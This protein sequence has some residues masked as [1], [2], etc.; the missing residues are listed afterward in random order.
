[1]EKT[2]FC[3][4]CGY[5]TNQKGHLIRHFQNKKPCPSTIADVSVED[6]LEEL[7][8][9]QYNDHTY[10]CEFCGKKF[11]SR[12]NKS[13]H[14]RTCKPTVSV[15][16]YMDL[17]TK[18]EALEQQVKNEAPTNITNNT[19][20]IQQN[21][22]I[23]IQRNDFARGENIKYLQPQFLLECFRDMDMIKVLEEIHFNPDHP[24]N[25]NVR[26][27]NVKQNLMEYIDNGQWIAK[28][29]EEVLDHLIMNGY[30]VLHTYY[31]DNKDD[32]EDNLENNEV[33]ESLRWLKMIYHEDKDVIKQLKD[34]A[35]LLVMNNK[36][37]LLQ[38]V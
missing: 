20:N 15:K 22:H 2:Y 37:L 4:R 14:K 30:R 3:K 33:D 17:K 27:K 25:H 35:F 12:S 9:K 28:K 7:Q 19:Q 24:E 18:V 26:V 21:I 6:L 29:K 31:K 8:Q 36:A 34:D 1:M 32:V 5:T 38:K 23:H 16:D 10:D 11:N 13:S